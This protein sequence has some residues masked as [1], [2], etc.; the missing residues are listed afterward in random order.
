MASFVSLTA[1]AVLAPIVVV[2]L[3]G[4]AA[5]SEYRCV[6]VDQSVRRVEVVVEDPVQNVPCEVV[7]WK[8]TEQPGVRSVLWTAETDAAYCTRKADELV[9]NLE[10]GGWSCAPVEAPATE[11]AREKT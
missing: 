7:Y 9:A 2:G 5:A 3:I 10:S 4:A 8:D 11:A 1:S 6:R